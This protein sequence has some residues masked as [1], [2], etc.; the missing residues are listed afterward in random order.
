LLAGIHLANYT[1]DYA[2]GF[3]RAAASLISEKASAPERPE[4]WHPTAGIFDQEGGYDTF[5]SLKIS[6]AS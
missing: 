3:D 2:V 5:Q 6:D 1:A 4:A